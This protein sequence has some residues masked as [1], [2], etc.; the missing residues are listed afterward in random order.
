M[1]DGQ[2]HRF[3]RELTCMELIMMYGTLS[4]PGGF[5]KFIGINQDHMGERRELKLRVAFIY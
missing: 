3:L 5:R 4:S 2:D 1:E